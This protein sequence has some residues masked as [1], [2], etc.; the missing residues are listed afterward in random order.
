MTASALGQ[1]KRHIVTRRLPSPNAPVTHPSSGLRLV[2]LQAELSAAFLSMAASIASCTS[3][4]ALSSCSKLLMI[5]GST[6]AVACVVQR[7]CV[8][9][10]YLARKSLVCIDSLQ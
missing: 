1:Q 7:S 3:N 4:A 9:V 8:C 5:L 2:C 6:L 10:L